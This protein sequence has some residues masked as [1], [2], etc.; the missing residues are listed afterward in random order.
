MDRGIR[1]QRPSRK[2]PARG[3][4]ERLHELVLY[5]LV[6]L[7]IGPSFGTIVVQSVLFADL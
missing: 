4:P 6:V 3:E 5:L 7:A 1:C 2:P